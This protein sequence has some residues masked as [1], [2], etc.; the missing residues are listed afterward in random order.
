[1]S[2]PKWSA[3][4]L[5]QP[6]DLV[7]PKTTPATSTYALNDPSFE[8]GGTGWTFEGGFVVQTP[9]GS[10]GAFNGT[11]ILAWGGAATA[12]GAVNNIRAPVAPGQTISARV[13]ANTNGH[14]GTA[15]SANIH[16]NWYNSGGSLIQS[17]QGP[18]TFAD[19]TFNWRAATVTAVAPSGAAFASIAL[20]ASRSGTSFIWF[21]SVTWDYV[22]ASPPDALTFKAIQAAAATSAASEPTWPT[23]A[24][25]TVVDG[26]VTWQAV[27]VSRVYWT[28]TPILKSSSPEPTW[29]TAVGGSVADGT[30]RW[31]AGVGQITDVNCPHSKVV[32]IG[33]SKIFA[34]DS[35]I[36]DFCATNNP[37]DWSTR[38]DAGYL[39][40]GIQTYGSN[41]V[42][43]L[44]LYRGNLMAMNS[45]GYSMWQIDPDPTNMAK[46]D[47]QPVGSTYHRSF[48]AVGNDS[49]LL[50]PLGV[51]TIGI[52]VGSTNL[53]IGGVGEPVDPLVKSYLA[54]VVQEP[55]ALYFPARGQYWLIFDS[56]ILVLTVNGAKN[57][58]WSR[59]VFP[60]TITD[61]TLAGD[62]LYLRST[63]GYV[64]KVDENSLYDDHV[65][66]TTCTISNATPAVVSCTAHGLSL[67]DTVIFATSGALPTGLTAGTTYYV[68]AAGLTANAFEVSAS[69][70]GAA[71]NTTS[72]GS[73]VHTLEHRVDFTGIMWWPYVDFGAIGV[74]KSLVG[75]DLVGTGTVKVSIGYDQRDFSI[76]TTDYTSEGDTVSG[77]I[78][79]IPITAPSFSLRLEYQAGQA[80]EWQAA[81]LY[82]LSSGAN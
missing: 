7:V 31:V 13:M 79:P 49:I 20:F 45:G 62:D 11:K 82:M 30:I 61:W 71:I 48:Q 69:Q 65:G 73:G 21:D 12:T 1:M 67:N 57:R 29:P 37:F 26:G 10:P 51:R 58:S 42:A 76:R 22:Y 28:A 50:T 80:W 63:S 81:A 27:T 66:P 44:G 23:I 72:A 32:A 64:W 16:I 33:A 38:Q 43:L 39:P 36:V 59:Y 54:S 19:G 34:G 40:T 56:Q 35:D 25:N 9:G 4:T 78:T 46:L 3:G 8:G 53:Q 14:T 68:I 55:L 47:E 74:D 5:Y 52:A 18:L 17:D 6:G 75:F 15:D 24:G 77:Q 70:G 2:T 60:E 41:P